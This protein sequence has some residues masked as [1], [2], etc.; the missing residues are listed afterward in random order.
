M[1]DGTNLGGDKSLVDAMAPKIMARID[2]LAAISQM[3]GGLARI[4]LT[5]EHR[6]ANDL[7]GDWMEAAGMRVHQDAV[8]NI[9]GRYEGTAD[10]AP[11]VMIG[12]H[13]DTVIDAGKYDGALGVLTGIAC[14]ERLAREGR[15]LPH[16]IEVI[17]FADEEGA[18]YDSTYLGS[19]AVAGCF[20]LTLL[21]R[22]DAAGV[23]MA[24]AM[25]AFGL[26][27]RR[28]GEA[29]RTPDEIL[30]YLEL[31]IEQGPALER[32]ALPVGVVT[33]IAGQTR[34]I[35][36]IDGEA[37]HAGT[38]PM[39]MRHD[40]LAGAAE[41]I[42][43]IEQTARD[44]PGRVATVGK[45]TAVPGAINVIPGHIQF[46]VDLRSANEDSRLS[47][48][49]EVERRIA[50]IADARSLSATIDNVHNVGGVACDPGLMTILAEAIESRG[51]QS[52]ELPSGAG[53]DAAVMAQLAPA[54]MIFLRCAGGI[55]HHPAESITEADAEIGAETLL[56]VLELHAEKSASA[57]ENSEEVP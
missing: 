54:G 6:R 9:V 19:R 53:H 51:L 33:G 36:S 45:I 38:V 56:A 3:S 23:R 42:L 11:A 57:A 12:S 8:G 37:G 15:R 43:A 44:G 24:D 39:A 18:R 26:D 35:V 5:P 1:I 55:S 47:A 30:A 13:L 32:A 2:A 4:Y 21:D 52:L 40:A 28:I 25:T 31:H 48:V 16:A 22:E 17:G 29:A 50:E 14:V 49:A 27:P 46:T 10:A 41:C 20:D 7:V 34:L